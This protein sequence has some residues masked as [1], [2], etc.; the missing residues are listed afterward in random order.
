MRVKRERDLTRTL[1]KVWEKQPMQTGSRRIV[2]AAAMFLFTGLLPAPGDAPASLAAYFEGDRLKEALLRLTPAYEAAVRRLSQTLDETCRFV[3][4][5]VIVARD[6][7]ALVA[8]KSYSSVKLKEDAPEPLEQMFFLYGIPAGVKD[9]AL[10][11]GK[12]YP[13]GKFAY[14]GRDKMEQSVN[15]LAVSKE[16]ALRAMERPAV[17]NAPAPK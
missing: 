13:A 8:V 14:T 4:A 12:V 11:E 17:P 3:R 10:W 16:W 1:A 5:E 9:G 2:F 6:G 15:A 7:G